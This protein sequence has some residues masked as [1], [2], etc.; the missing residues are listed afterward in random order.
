[1][2][3]LQDDPF[4]ILQKF[5]QVNVKTIFRWETIT[6]VHAVL[7]KLKECWLPVSSFFLYFCPDLWSSSPSPRRSKSPKTETMYQHHPKD[8]LG[9]VVIV[10]QYKK[11]YNF[12]NL[13]YLRPKGQLYGGK[14][15]IAEGIR[16]L[17]PSQLT[18]DRICYSRDEFSS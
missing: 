12:I 1:M 18:S 17:M 16:F 14:M 8:K 4:K 5:R 7:T 3:F 11:N 15:V 10:S 9:L 2:S 6:K 13:N